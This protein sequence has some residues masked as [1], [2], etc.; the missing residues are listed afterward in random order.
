MGGRA[1]PLGS[2]GTFRRDVPQF[3]RLST[4]DTQEAN[5]DSS[6]SKLSSRSALES[7][8][9]QDIY[10]FDGR[11]QAIEPRFGALK[12]PGHAVRGDDPER[13]KREARKA[14]E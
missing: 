3:C 13:E 1:I 10:Q 7:Q 11:A 14:Q 4:R 6:S 12:V 5:L 2:V 9:N 8:K